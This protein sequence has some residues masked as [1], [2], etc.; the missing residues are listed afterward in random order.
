MAVALRLGISV[1]VA[2]TCRCGASTDTGG[3]VYRYGLVC[4]RA[5]IKIARHQAL[6]ESIARTISSAGTPVSK[7][8]TGRSR[9]DGLTL[10]PWKG[11]KPL[12]WDVIV[13]STSAHSY[14]HVISQSPLVSVSGAAH[15]VRRLG[16]STRTPT[17]TM[18]ATMRRYRTEQTN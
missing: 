11:G 15:E 1:C 14:L 2:H 16:S 10:I 3:G 5:L 4:K 6:N 9:S 18:K 12:T 8:P 17:D 13:V 7:E